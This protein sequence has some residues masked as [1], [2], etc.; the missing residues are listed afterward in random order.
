METTL[1]IVAII[2]VSALAS[3]G[4]Y[5]TCLKEMEEFDKKKES[6]LSYRTNEEFVKS[7]SQKTIE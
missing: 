4:Y 7:D 6:S 3:Y 2:V 5:L 1:I